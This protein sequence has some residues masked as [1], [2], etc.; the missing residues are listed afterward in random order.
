MRPGRWSLQT[1]PDVAIEPRAKAG[2]GVRQ[3]VPAI[4]E[5]AQNERFN[6]FQDKF[7]DVAVG[8]SVHIRLRTG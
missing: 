7:P 5:R 3:L 8:S 1:R 2:A 4:P 6:L